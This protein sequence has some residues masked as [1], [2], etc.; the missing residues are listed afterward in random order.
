MCRIL[1]ASLDSKER[2]KREWMEKGRHNETTA[3]G[4]IKKKLNDKNWS[5]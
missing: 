3:I 4:Q 1:N 5:V 2:V